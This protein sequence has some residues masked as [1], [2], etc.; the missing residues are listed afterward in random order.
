VGSYEQG[1]EISVY[2]KG[3]RISCL[4]EFCFFQEGLCSMEL[5]GLFSRC[6]IFMNYEYNYRRF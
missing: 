1:N 4:R 3:R 6:Q 2:I 5:I